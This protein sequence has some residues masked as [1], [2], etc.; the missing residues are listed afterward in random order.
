MDSPQQWLRV[1]VLF[2]DRLVEERLCRPHQALTIG[3]SPRCTLTVPAPGLPRRW[4][5]FELRRGRRELRLA[6]AME[7]RWA[8]DGGTSA[9]ASGAVGAE[10]AR[11]PAGARHARQGGGRRE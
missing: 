6:P 4:R 3:S 2:G 1:G 11:R 10:T 9:A 8:G 5:L 7:A